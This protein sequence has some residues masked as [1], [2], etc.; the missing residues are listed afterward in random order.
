MRRFL[1]VATIGLAAAACGGSTG[2]PVP[3]RTTAPV[4]GSTAGAISG[5]TLAPAQG[6]SA[7]LPGGGQQAGGG[8][9]TV[10][11]TGGA[12]PGSFTLVGDPHCSDGL[13]PGSYG[14]QLSDATVTAP[15][16]LSSVQII[17]PKTPASGS[18]TNLLVT[19]GPLL[20]GTEYDISDVSGGTASGTFAPSGS[21]AQI[22]VTGTTKDGVGI[23]ATVICE[24][25]IQGGQ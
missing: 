14:V 10:V 16:Q 9:A 18:Q 17:L 13:L 22:H 3:G 15:N 24:T 7:A 23:D 8:S 25:V 11:L 6:A 19:L 2:T 20:G 12:N 5:A 21:G 1:F 4:P